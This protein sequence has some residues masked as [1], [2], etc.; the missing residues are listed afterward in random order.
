MAGAFLPPVN[1]MLT[2]HGLPLLEVTAL[3]IVR[4]RK[5]A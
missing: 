3:I 2:R 1:L 5:A 4:P